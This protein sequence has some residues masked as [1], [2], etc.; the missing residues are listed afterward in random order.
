MG[1]PV[2]VYSYDDPG[3]P[4]LGTCKPSEIINIL[5]K[6]LIDGYGDKTPAG[7]TVEF[8]DASNAI[9]FRNSPIEGSGGFVKLWPKSAGDIARD[10]IFMQT[11]PFINSI[12]PDWSLTPG[13]SFRNIFFNGHGNVLRW[14]MYATS[15]CFYLF[16][17]G[18]TS[19]YGA[20]VAMGTTSFPSVFV[21][22]FQSFIPGDLNT[23]V[24]I[25]KNSSTA[26]EP[27]NSTS[28]P[29]A[30]F[31]ISVSANLFKA[32]ET[33][34]FNNYKSIG[35]QQ[36][37]VISQTW[38]TTLIADTPPSSFNMMFSP[39]ILGLSST[40]MDQ[41]GSSTNSQYQDS[42]GTN[43]CRSMLQPAMRGIMP[44]L[45]FSPF[46][47]CANEPIFYPWIADGVEWHL[48]GQYHFGGSRTW[49][50]LGDWYA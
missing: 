49:L 12:D 32:Y 48:L 40:Y 4:S 41:T 46:Y 19:S 13:A 21:G 29:L 11:A 45:Y 3:A 47:G 42:E 38:G 34:N 33:T 6:C 43:V 18:T 50:T 31:Q 15:R 27:L 1:L 36:F 26:D 22:D 35:F 10:L 24:A 16:F 17:Y 2:T 44:G 8:E 28:Y 5:K 7:W 9:V 14:R 25:G 23:F 20:N 39:I 37:G 30:L